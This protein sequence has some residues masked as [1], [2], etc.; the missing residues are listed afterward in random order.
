MKVLLY[1]DSFFELGICVLMC[2]VVLCITWVV[3]DRF[4]NEI[5][6]LECVGTLEVLN[7]FDMTSI[8][9]F[10]YYEIYLM[11]LMKPWHVI[12]DMISCYDLW[13]FNVLI[14][15]EEGRQRIYS[16]LYVLQRIHDVYDFNIHPFNN[17]PLREDLVSSNLGIPCLLQ[18]SA[19]YSWKLV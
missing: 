7:A 14:K 8:L 19:P 16:L 18:T 10:W 6:K 3:Y 13:H 17:V 2:C 4:R 9:R 11:T 5:C 12:I 15:K 1:C